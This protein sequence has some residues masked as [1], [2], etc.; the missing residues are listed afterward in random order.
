LGRRPRDLKCSSNSRRAF[1][2]GTKEIRGMPESRTGTHPKPKRLLQR[3]SSKPQRYPHHLEF[4]IRHPFQP[5]H[6]HSPIIFEIPPFNRHP[7]NKL[8]LSNIRHLETE[9]NSFKLSSEEQPMGRSAVRHFGQADIE[10]LK[11]ITDDWP[12]MSRH[13][14]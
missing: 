9:D 3:P 4:R 1:F 14:F 7:M 11:G 5:S 2:C 6:D 13:V 12:E 10:P 8:E